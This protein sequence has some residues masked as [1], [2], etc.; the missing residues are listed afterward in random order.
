MPR[1][2]ATMVAQSYSIATYISLGLG[3]PVRGP[4]AAGR[5]WRSK[6]TLT[7]TSYIPSRIVHVIKTLID[8]KVILTR[9]Q[10]HVR[11]YLM[12]IDI[13]S[14]VTLSLMLS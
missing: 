9:A 7:K 6:T 13:T 5:A 2:K 1:P 10:D 12:P 3:G 11:Y 8:H 14:A 4:G